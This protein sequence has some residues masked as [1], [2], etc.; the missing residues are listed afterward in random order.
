MSESKIYFI[1]STLFIFSIILFSFSKSLLELISIPE[2]FIFILF[3]FYLMRL[4]GKDIK[5]VKSNY[6]WFVNLYALIM[7]AGIV[8]A[9]FCGYYN[10]ENFK[11]V[12]RIYEYFAIFI[13]TINL[14]KDK[15]KISNILNS[16][17]IMGI[18]VSLNAIFQKLI[19]PQITSQ[20]QPWGPVWVAQYTKENFRVYS[21]FDNPIYLGIFAVLWMG[22]TGTLFFH[23]YKKISKKIPLFLLFL[24]A[25]CTMILTGSRAALIGAIF[26]L[27]V[28]V[29]IKFSLKKTVPLILFV[30]VLAFFI[31]NFFGRLQRIFYHHE[32]NISQR[33]LAY[34][35]AINMIRD[36]P[37]LGIGAGNY[38]EVYKENYK[39]SAASSDPVTFTAEN[40]F[41]EIGAQTGIL[42]LLLYSLFYVFCFKNLNFVYKNSKD[43]YLR[44]LSLG[45]G[46]SLIG[47]LASS[48]F[49]TI[50]TVP[51]NM[52][53]WLF[54]GI[55]ESLKNVTLQECTEAVKR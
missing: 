15:T 2:I 9:F 50:N 4:M 25:L 34:Q 51:L 47:L 26:V 54:F 23:Y 37:L 7:V 30:V 3:F 43:K 28:I 29:G 49:A 6:Y 1:F 53:L 8:K 44:C 33:F 46:I 18:F 45:I 42:G 11:Y 35:S 19:G 39:F 10:F 38:R 24:L 40:N 31:P 32:T 52:I 16:F 41:L 27:I 22:I 5:I 20:V 14:I 36:N 48:L 55:G 17:M 12:F 13:L 21:F